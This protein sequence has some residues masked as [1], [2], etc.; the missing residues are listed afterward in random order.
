MTENSESVELTDD[1]PTTIEVGANI[2]PLNLENVLASFGDIVAEVTISPKSSG[3]A[4]RGRKANTSFD[5]T[6]VARAFESA[7]KSV[8]SSKNFDSIDVET[9][10][11]MTVGEF[12]IQLATLGYTATQCVSALV[13]KCDKMTEKHARSLYAKA[14]TEHRNRCILQRVVPSGH[15]CSDKYLSHSATAY[16]KYVKGQLELTDCSGD[17]QFPWNSKYRTSSADTSWYPTMLGWTKIELLE[18][19]ERKILAVL[20]SYKNKDGTYR[21]DCPLSEAQR[22]AP[23]LIRKAIAEEAEKFFKAIGAAITEHRTVFTVQRERNSVGTMDTVAFDEEI[24]W[25]AITVD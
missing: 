17:K 21:E 14:K 9:R 22:S 16:N 2:P 6:E 12:I 13:F 4:K 15:K 11:N 24:D 25:D 10:Y 7:V 23:T 8:R 18:K 3:G 5:P 19:Q 1:E 20:D